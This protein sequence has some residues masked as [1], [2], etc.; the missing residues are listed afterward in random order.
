MLEIN[1]SEQVAHIL[2]DEYEYEN[3]VYVSRNA[4]NGQIVS[5]GFG[6]GKTQLGVTT[7]KKVKRIGC[8]NFKSLLEEKKLY[9]PDADTISEISTFIE[10]K[11]SYEADEGYNDDLV[12]TLVLFS[13]L[14]TNP[15][16]KELSNINLRQVM[17]ENRM[18][19]IEENLTPFGFI[20]NGLDNDVIVDGS[21]Q[22]WNT[23]EEL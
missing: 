23:I 22:V 6:A 12:M 15:Y 21:G 7:D 16:F 8:F 5:G 19:S 18:K 3:I 4:K 17:Y 11:Q 10:K 14:T 9:I 20:N 2:H 1:S 13:W